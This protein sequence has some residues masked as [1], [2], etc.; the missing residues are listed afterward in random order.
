MSETD[1]QHATGP[2][3]GSRR[4][5]P[6]AGAGVANGLDPEGCA[7]TATEAALRQLGAPTADLVLVFFSRHFVEH[8][9][10]I[11]DAVRALTFP[12]ALIGVST[13][14]VLGGTQCFE[15]QPA[16][17]VLAL[18]L[19]GVTLRAFTGDDLPEPGQTPESAG[20]MA[21]A[22]G[23]G[24]GHRATLV[25]CDPFSTALV[26][27]L[28]AIDE[29]CASVNGGPVLGGMASA[30]ESPGGNAL[31][32]NDT[33]A[34]DG[35]VGVSLSGPVRVDTLVS[36]GCKPFGPAMVVTKSKRNLLFELGGTR[37]TDA[38]KQAAASLSEEERKSLSGGLQLGIVTDEYKERFGRGD[39]LLRAIL[40]ADEDNGIVAVADGVRVGQ[41]VRFHYLDA[42]SAVDDL[43]MLLDAQKLH[44]PPV[45][46]LMISCTGRGSQLF[47]NGN[48]D[49]EAFARA[50]APPAT[51]ASMALGGQPVGSVEASVPLAGMSAAG[52]IAPTAG[53][54]RLHAQSVVAALFRA[55]K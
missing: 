27:L 25:F 32:V 19:P 43:G 1:P 17:S 51:G 34:R 49:P 29:A 26:K 24:Q 4:A 2:I 48:H 54:S 7:R 38:L 35:V 37:A 16:I 8:A 31:V 6:S 45:G 3:Q 40:A 30:G 9:Q 42:A 20:A 23:A 46:A 33:I 44:G 5:G 15:R 13:E 18:R 12:S 28:P 52:E 41:T 11:T 21:A 55:A 39:Y 47:K 36:H 50:F 10:A 22:L 14:S 53:R